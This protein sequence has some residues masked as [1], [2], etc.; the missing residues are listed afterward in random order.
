MKLRERIR[1]WYQ[2]RFRGFVAAPAQYGG[3]GTSWQEHK[4]HEVGFTCHGL[5]PDGSPCGQ[6]L[7]FRS[8]D[9][10]IREQDHRDGC[11]GFVPTE[12]AG[13][14]TIVHCLCPITDARHVKICPSCGL[15]HWNDA[16]P[17]TSI[18]RRHA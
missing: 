11:E 3:R 6:V 9:L 16:T 1:A 7:A 4:R 14:K 2:R 5:R 17:Q 18:S 10:V 12:N 15:G 8:S 13:G